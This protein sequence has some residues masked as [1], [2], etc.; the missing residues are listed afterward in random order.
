MTQ[1]FLRVS[2]Y[3]KVVWLTVDESVDGVIL[4]V[5]DY[6]EWPTQKK[7]W[8]TLLTKLEQ[9]HP[10][11]PPGVVYTLV[12]EARA[13]FQYLMVS[14]LSSVAK[15]KQLEETFPN[16]QFRGNWVAPATKN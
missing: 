8:Q 12:L 11:I 15:V 10:W 9:E 16:S 14:P 7:P 2:R 3:G 6:I 1:Y 4:P 5:L 13:I